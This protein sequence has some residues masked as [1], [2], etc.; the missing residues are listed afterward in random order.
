[1][2][3]LVPIHILLP[4]LQAPSCPSSFISRTFSFIPLLFPFV[5]ASLSYCLPPGQWQEGWIPQLLIFFCLGVSAGAFIQ[6][7]VS[8]KWDDLEGTKEEGK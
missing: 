8:S 4:S 3:Q 1:M 5:E 2:Q 6:V 7:T